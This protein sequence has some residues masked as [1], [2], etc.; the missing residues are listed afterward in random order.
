MD[1][2]G[3]WGC[4]AASS[5]ASP[6]PSTFSSTGGSWAPAGILGG[7]VDGTGRVER[8]ARGSAFIAGL[9]AACRRWPRRGRASR[10]DTHRATTC[11]AGRG[12]P[13]R[14]ASAPASPTAAPA[15]TASA[16]SRACRC[17]ALSATGLLSSCAGGADDRSVPPR[18]GSDLMLRL[19]SGLRGGSLFGAGTAGLGHDRHR[20]R[21]RA[22][23][24]SSAPGT[25]RWPSSW[26]ARSCPWRS[27]GVW[28]PR[29]A[30]P[31][32]GGC[33]PERRRAGIDARRSSSARRSSASGWG[34]A[35][36]CPGPAMASL[37]Y[38]GL[39]GAAFFVA[40]IA[41]MAGA[42]AV[43]RTRAVAA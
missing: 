14:R 33:F 13:S 5:S 28:P 35:G 43:M 16:A 32:L 31:L 17:A 12:G 26:A 41:G 23:S 24:T 9:V 7:L 18:P 2:T 29:R 40:M 22:G 19:S 27:P 6:P 4:S 1:R 20:P 10:D 37:S 25:R 21:C 38:G 11:R 42:H 36:L 15:A 34:L 3:S 30:R 39:G 8:W